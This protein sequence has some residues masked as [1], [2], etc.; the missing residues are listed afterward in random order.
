MKWAF[1]LIWRETGTVSGS[2]VRAFDRDEGKS[3][4]ISESES[5]SNSESRDD[6]LG[7]KKR[8]D[9]EEAK[10]KGRKTVRG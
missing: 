3:P 6:G 4:S 1:L 5:E 9:S 8:T 7:T 10:E 2:G